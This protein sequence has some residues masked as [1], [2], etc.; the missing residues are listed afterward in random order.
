MNRLK[1]GAAAVLLLVLVIVMIQ[2]RDPIE[3]RLLFATVTMPHSIL[4][5][6]TTVLGMTAG[7][8]IAWF[9]LRPAKKAKAAPAEPAPPSPQEP[10]ST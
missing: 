8:L 4:L 9:A 5:L 3:T 2:N 10:K 1:M 6:A 7:G